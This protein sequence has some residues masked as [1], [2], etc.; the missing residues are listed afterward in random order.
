M[1]VKMDLSISEFRE[2]IQKD[3]T[4]VDYLNAFLNLPVML[5]LISISP[6]MT[7]LFDLQLYSRRLTYSSASKAF[8]IEPHEDL[9]V[10]VSR[11][12]TQLVKN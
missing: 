8:S 11:S 9:K 12:F 7:F 6:E 5:K 3:S 4:F 10:Y 1:A 2:I